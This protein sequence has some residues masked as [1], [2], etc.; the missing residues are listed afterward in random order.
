MD[1]EWSAELAAMNARA[2]ARQQT[3]DNLA[4]AVIFACAAVLIY[5]A[6]GGA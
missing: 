1:D 6:L 2:R 3:L 5:V 4:I